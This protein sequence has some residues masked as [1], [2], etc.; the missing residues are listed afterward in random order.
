VDLDPRYVAMDGLLLC[1]VAGGAVTDVRSGKVYNAL[2]YS[3]IVAGIVLNSWLPSP[4]AI[5][6]GASLLGLLVGG[7]PLFL[8]FLA[9]SIGAGDV[10]LMAAVGAF[11]GPTRTLDVLLYTCL[12][13]AVLAI[14]VILWREGYGGLRLRLGAAF[15]FRRGDDGFA[16]LRFPFGVAIFVGACWAVA[17]RHLGVSMLDALKAAGA[18]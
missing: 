5:G 16:R 9:N 14:A 2:T 18:S 11:L 8:A 10:K 3:A 1:I 15:R 6:P 7:G 13:G 17:E 12:A 4:P